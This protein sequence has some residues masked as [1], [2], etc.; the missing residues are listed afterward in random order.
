MSFLQPISNTFLLFRLNL[1][2]VVGLVALRGLKGKP[3][4]FSS[5]LSG[6]WNTNYIRFLSVA[7]KWIIFVLRVFGYRPLLLTFSYCAF[8]SVNWMVVT[9]QLL[10]L[11][12]ET[13]LLYEY[14]LVTKRS[15]CAPLLVH[16]YQITFQRL[17]IFSAI[18]SPLS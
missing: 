9:I 18:R 13:E 8:T 10:D 11:Q 5:V 15:L 17:D 12:L 4:I 7:F 3:P 2:E 14:R 1:Q 16:R 6:I